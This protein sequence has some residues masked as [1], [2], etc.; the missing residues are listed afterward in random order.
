MPSCLLPSP[1]MLSIPSPKFRLSPTRCISP[2]ELPTVQS[3]KESITVNSRGGC[4]NVRFKTSLD[5][6]TNIQHWMLLEQ[7]TQTQNSCSFCDLF[8]SMTLTPDTWN[9]SEID[10]LICWFCGNWPIKSHLTGQVSSPKSVKVEHV[11]DS[12]CTQCDADVV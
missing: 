10:A 8:W 1:A 9:T 5:N 4:T 3:A 7:R 12:E 6:V 2:A 11:Y